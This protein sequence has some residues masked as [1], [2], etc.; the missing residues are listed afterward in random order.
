M[1]IVS[2]TTLII[3]DIKYY[4]EAGAEQT[5][6]VHRGDKDGPVLA[7][8][9]PCLTESGATDIHMN[10]DPPFTVHFQ[11]SS[12]LLPFFHGKTTFNFEGNRYHWKGHTALIDDDSGVLQAAFDAKLFEHEPDHLGKLVVSYDG[13]KMLDLVVISCLLVQERSDEGKLS[14]RRLFKRRANGS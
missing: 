5:I 1:Y 2:K 10:T 13:Q 3:Q 8:G 9:K 4:C 6:T 14:V 11:H 7:T 12:S